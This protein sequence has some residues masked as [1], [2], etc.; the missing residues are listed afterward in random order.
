MVANDNLI[1]GATVGG[2][3]FATKVVRAGVGCLA[4]ISFPC[5]FLALGLVFSTTA[6]VA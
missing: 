2:L 5:L 6:T 1:G 3:L 4:A